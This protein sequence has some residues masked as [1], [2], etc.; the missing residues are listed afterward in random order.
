MGSTSPPQPYRLSREVAIGRSS[1]YS[2]LPTTR[3]NL[4][5]VHFCAARLS[6]YYWFWETLFFFCFTLHTFSSVYFTGTTNA[7]QPRNLFPLPPFLP[8]GPLGFVRLD[9]YHT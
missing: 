5:T 1:S 4:G 6:L 2:F 7:H 3:R 8:P 9:L